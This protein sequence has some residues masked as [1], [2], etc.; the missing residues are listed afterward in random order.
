MV[1]TFGALIAPTFGSATVAGIPEVCGIKPGRRFC[2]RTNPN[3]G[4]ID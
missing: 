3:V 1:R 2:E 4:A